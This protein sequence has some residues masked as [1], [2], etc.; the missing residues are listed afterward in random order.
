MDDDDDG[1]SGKNIEQES[2][3]SVTVGKEDTEAIKEQI[4]GQTI[5]PPLIADKL[6]EETET[7]EGTYFE[8]LFGDDIDLTPASAPSVNVSTDQPFDGPVEDMYEGTFY[9]Y[10]N[11]SFW[12]GINKGQPAPGP[13]PS[14][15][16]IPEVGPS[17]EAVD[18]G[19]DNSTD[20]ST[21]DGTGTEKDE[22][23]KDD[24][25]KD[26][27]DDDKADGNQQG[28]TD[29]GKNETAAP[30]ATDQEEPEDK[31]E[32]PTPSGNVTKGPESESIPD[33]VDKVSN[34]TKP[35][36]NEEDQGENQEDSGD[37]WSDNTNVPETEDSNA[38][39]EES[40][41]ESNEDDTQDDSEVNQEDDSEEASDTSDL[42]DEKN[43]NV[44]DGINNIN[45]EEKE[46]D[47]PKTP[48]NSTTWVSSQMN[49][50]FNSNKTSLNQNSKEITVLMPASANERKNRRKLL[51]VDPLSALTSS[52]FSYVVTTA[53]PD[54]IS[55]NATDTPPKTEEAI[56]ASVM[57][58]I[59]AIQSLADGDSEEQALDILWNVLF[60]SGV[61]LA[62]IL[63]IHIVILCVLWLLKVEEVPKMLHLPR[64]ELLAFMMILPM[65]TAAGAAC[66]Q[67]TSPG[68][69]A[70][71]VIFGIIIPFGFLLGAGIFLMLAIIRPTISKRRA[72]YVV[73]E[74]E[75]M[76]AAPTDQQIA[77]FRESR[78]DVE[79][80]QG[81]GNNL[82]TSMLGQNVRDSMADD[83]SSE[84]ADS[85]AAT[86]TETGRRGTQPPARRGVRSFMYKWILSP[87]FGF[88]SP[89]RAPNREQAQPAWLGRMKLDAVFVK[90]FGCFFEDAHGPQVYRV[91][92]R[93]DSMASPVSD[94]EFVGAGILV[95]VGTQGA[96][97]VLQTYGIIFAA[98]KMVLFAVIINSPGGVNNVAQ[99]V[100][101]LLV[102]LL[103]VVYLRVCV[104]Y[105]LRIELGAEIVAAVCDFAVFVCGIILIA[106]QDWSSSERNSMGIAMI[107]LQAVGFLVFITIRVGLALRTASITIM[108]AAKKFLKRSKQPTT[109]SN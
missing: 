86:D 82:T 83:N 63:G 66:L 7:E 84:A 56:G 97:Q 61:L 18:S 95:P 81:S 67:S 13:A 73:E 47:S 14:P 39:N 42:G 31:S 17:P 99:V 11:P 109:I 21:D 9:V 85:E 53:T 88:S 102:A 2:S 8:A 52:G 40:E 29:P 23:E 16:P 15:D 108:P 34:S 33:K 90:R 75:A 94:R 27:T 24:A 105:R 57:S 51:L 50:S 35:V 77:M 22:T 79:S 70:A 36:D 30:P 43:K 78:A 100:A 107:A 10:E 4:D 3:P 91:S 41:D 45:K 106:K 92:S 58:R 49:T 76:A 62:A 103:H 64:L 69:I 19:A 72:V 38:N 20:N 60:W 68:A 65:I 98:M 54:I 48:S 28:E 46:K 55:Q 104:P 101:L 71:G 93:Y 32:A 37:E 12:G 80:S 96:M 44:T 26:D 59:R 87:L 1:S 74:S 89:H 5:E 25:E 6:E